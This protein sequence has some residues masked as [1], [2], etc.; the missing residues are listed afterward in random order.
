MMTSQSAD[1][2]ECNDEYEVIDDQLKYSVTKIARF[3]LKHTY[4]MFSQLSLLDFA[5]HVLICIFYQHI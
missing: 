4:L 3:E 1:Y 5:L 2:V